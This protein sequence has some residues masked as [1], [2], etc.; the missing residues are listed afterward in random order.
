MHSIYV[1]M[2]LAFRKGR[3]YTRLAARMSLIAPLHFV[4]RET[5]WHR[6]RTSIWRTRAKVA[7][8]ALTRVR[9]CTSRTSFTESETDPSVVAMQRPRSDN[10]NGRFEM[11]KIRETLPN[12]S[13]SSCPS[14]YGKINKK[15]KTTNRLRL[16]RRDARNRRAPCDS[17][18]RAE[19]E[20][21]VRVADENTRY[22]ILYKSSTRVKIGGS[23]IRA[24]RG[25]ECDTRKREVFAPIST[26]PRFRDIF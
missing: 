19:I 13:Q 2:Y 24:P 9:K 26:Y 3:R 11:E 10:Q 15:E 8:S 7:R 1:S 4:D 25:G 20:I 18:G 5:R 6:R 17:A 22:V 21:S 16:P 14:K 23:R 12:E